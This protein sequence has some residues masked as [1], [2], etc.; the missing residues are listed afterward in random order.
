MFRTFD[1]IGGFT[2][3]LAP[4]GWLLPW[5]WLRS[6]C[7]S[8]TDGTGQ[9]RTASTCSPNCIRTAAT[10]NI[11]IIIQQHFALFHDAKELPNCVFGRKISSPFFREI[12][13]Q[14]FAR[15]IVLCARYS[16][17]DL[18]CILS[19][20][21]L[22]CKGFICAVLCARYCYLA[23]DLFFVQGIITLH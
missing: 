11:N 18:N 22:H 9:S 12:P 10:C 19:K 16:Y 23:R 21:M 6:R 13:Q 14:Y 1:I 3:Y 2:Y 8:G 5:V 4:S 17:R 15:R 7:L 20:V